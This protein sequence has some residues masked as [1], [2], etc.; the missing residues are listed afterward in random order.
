MEEAEYGSLRF[1]NGDWW[2][3]YK[4]PNCGLWVRYFHFNKDKNSCCFCLEKEN[5]E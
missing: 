1:V 2:D 3:I 5:K 4:C